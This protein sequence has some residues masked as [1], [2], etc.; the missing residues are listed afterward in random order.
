MMWF[1]EENQKAYV[2][3]LRIEVALRELLKA[4]MAAEFGTQWRKRLPGEFLKKVKSS[5]TEENQPQFGFLRLGPLYYLTF[6]ELLTV[7]QQRAGRQVAERFGGDVFLKQLEGLFSP[8]N[9]LSHSRP[10][11]SGGLR[12]I[13]TLYSQMETALTIEGLEDVLRSPDT[14]ILQDKAAE[15]IIGGFEDALSAL[16][17]L[18]PKLPVLEMFEEV[19]AQFWWADDSLAGFQR[20]IVETAVAKTEAYNSIPGGVG[21]AGAR[22]RLCEEQDLQGSFRSSIEELK[23]LRS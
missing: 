10:V 18:P 20:E 12:A 6:G 17:D 1:E 13:E 16:S 15:A 21:A 19:R 4:S 23:K 11:S 22:Q 5:Q 2:L 8:R 3:L 14:G 7:L 9:A